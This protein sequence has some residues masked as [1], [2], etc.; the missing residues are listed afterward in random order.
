MALES[1]WARLK[2]VG[3][4]T[5]RPIPTI[6]SATSLVLDASSNTFIVSGTTAITNINTTAAGIRPGR[7][8][9]FHTSDAIGP[10]WTDTAIASAANGTV[11]ISASLTQAKGTTLT[12]QQFND[13]SWREIARAVNG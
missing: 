3:G 9:Y 6:A 11:S 1:V 4:G 8:C 5:D 7:I 10:A 12:L 2:A 13:G